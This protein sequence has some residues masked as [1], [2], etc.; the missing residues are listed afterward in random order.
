[1]LCLSVTIVAR[2]YT[3]SRILTYMCIIMQE[4]NN[5]LNCHSFL[6]DDHFNVDHSHHD[7]STV[8]TTLEIENE[9]RHK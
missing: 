5:S 6:L 3:I 1:M 4:V 7:F 2:Y 9:N 8:D